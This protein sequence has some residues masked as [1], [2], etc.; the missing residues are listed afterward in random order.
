MQFNACATPDM[1][2]AGGWYGD[3]VCDLCEYY[4]LSGHRDPDCGDLVT[5]SACGSN[6]VCAEYFDGL[7]GKFGCE[8]IQGVRDPDCGCGDGAVAPLMSGLTVEFCDGTTFAATT[9]TMCTQYGFASGTVTC[10][11]GCAPNLEMC[12]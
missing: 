10:G 8:E 5:E 2:E 12:F 6:G 3:G 4:S 11:A 1:C 9:P 7:V